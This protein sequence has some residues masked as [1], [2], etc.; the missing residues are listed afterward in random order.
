MRMFEPVKLL[1]IYK[2]Y[3]WGGE[4]LQQYYG[5]KSDSDIWAESWELSAHKDGTVS[6]Q[7]AYNKIVLFWN[8]SKEKGNKFWV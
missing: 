8:T 3:L 5:K 4:K 7:T 6:L 2:S 1:P